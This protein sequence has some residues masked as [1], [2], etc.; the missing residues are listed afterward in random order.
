[1]KY[2]LFALLAMALLLPVRGVL[3]GSIISVGDVSP[4]VATAN[5]SQRFSADYE[6]MYSVESCLLYVDGQNEGSMSLS[7]SLSGT[8][9][10]SFTFEEAG[11]HTVYIRCETVYGN[12]QNSSTATV[13]VSAMDDESPSRPGDLR[14]TSSTSDSTASFSW[15]AST[16]DT[17][18]V[19]YEIQIDGGAFAPIGDTTSYTASA[20]ADG[21]YQFGVRAVDGSGNASSTASVTFTIDADA[22]SDDGDTTVSLTPP[23]ELDQMEVDADLVVQ[24]ASRT[25]LE[26]QTG[27][28]CEWSSSASASMVVSV[29]GSI[30][31][32]DTRT[33]IENF[34]ACGTRSTFHLGAGERLGAVNSYK[35]AF[36]RVPSSESHWNDVIKIGNGRF[37][38]EVSASAEANA[39]VTFKK[40]YLRDASMSV[41]SDRNAVYVMAYG[42]RPLPRNLSSEA[43]AIVTFKAV[44]G[45]NPSSATDWDAVRAVAYSGATR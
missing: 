24:V 30:T 31:D 21:T 40:I 9:S 1:M 5:V 29:F 43:A 18:V 17:A 19:R 26:A 7:G 35:A 33:A 32:A 14:V 22:S 45:Y 2:G 11:N 44:Y 4:T 12:V 8:A 3:A 27:R 20:M 6:S 13:T 38:A 23:F 28:E 34:A 25:E 39:K 16:D 42:L 36:G 15:D 41:E 10:A 37:T